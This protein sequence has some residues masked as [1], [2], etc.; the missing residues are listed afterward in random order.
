MV[1]L[2]NFAPLSCASSLKTSLDKRLL[3]LAECV[4]FGPV[5]A[6]RAI[7]VECESRLSDKARC[8]ALLLDL[9]DKTV[10]GCFDSRLV[11]GFRR[12]LP[13]WDVEMGDDERGF[14]KKLGEFIAIFGHG[15]QTYSPEDEVVIISLID[16]LLAS[17]EAME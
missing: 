13:H 1:R 16:V 15:K 12:W 7:V 17:I 14:Y 11:D 2:K 5:D 9:V 6:M 10:E 3:R 4:E 8:A